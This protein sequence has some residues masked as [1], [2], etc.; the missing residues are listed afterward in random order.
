MKSRSHGGL[1]AK[2]LLRHVNPARAWRLNHAL[3][4]AQNVCALTKVGIVLNFLFSMFSFAWQKHVYVFGG[5][6]RGNIGFIAPT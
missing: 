5:V 3:R 6:C 2:G 4:D 1:A